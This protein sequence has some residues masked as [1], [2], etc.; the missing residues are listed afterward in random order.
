M[1]VYN[2]DYK[3]WFANNDLLS[4]DDFDFLKQEL[5]STR[6]YS[7]CLSGA[8]YMSVNDL[9]DIYDILGDYQSR[10]WYVSADPVSGSLYSVTSV[11]P[12]HATP[13][14]KNNYTDYYTKY[15][16]EY[17]LTLK[18]LFTP[19][20]L[21]KD[22]SKN[23]YYV[24]VATTD[25]I[26]FTTI[27]RDFVIDGVKLKEGHRVLV[28]NQSTNIILLSTADPKTYF[29]G[30]YT[31]VQ[32]L[33]ATIEYQYYNEENG[34]YKFING[35]LV[36][37]TDL[38]DYNQCIRYSVSVKLGDVNRE[39]QF[40]LSRLL[41]GYFPLTSLGQPIEFKE[42][43][44]WILRNRVDY[45]NLFEINYYDIIK[46]GTQS[47]NFEGV[48]YS[49]PERTLSIGEFGVILNTQEGKSNI[50]K[51][52]YKVNL[53][54]ITQTSKYYW[55]CG[56]E[57]TLLKVRKHDFFID[58][59]ILEDI[60]TTLP[61]L[62]KTNL[63]SVSFFDDLNGAVVGE[64]NTILYTRNGGIEWQRIEIEDFIDFDYN[65]V[66]YSTNFSFFISGN[67]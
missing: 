30:N 44:N 21:I 29:T 11:P 35:G 61:N 51:N 42:K 36:R 13:I 14:G 41:D 27:T 38:A 50:I 65:R 28:K 46:H 48:T 56:D 63:S 54:S 49:I 24:D 57:N 23:F 64:L 67:S 17:G 22:T 26:D 34:I 59:I 2:N 8:T 47:Y 39:K 43:H 15:V 7:R 16:Q 9:S 40:H 3:K 4:K 12:Q 18:N 31:I 53:R 55:I 60:P 32:D 37:E 52:K 25:I 20:K 33:G 66:L 62:I 19:Y 6:L 58:R 1:W 45:N 5:K 10:S